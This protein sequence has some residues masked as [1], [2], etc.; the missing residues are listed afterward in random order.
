MKKGNNQSNSASSVSLDRKNSFTAADSLPVKLL[1]DEDVLLS[2]KKKGVIPPAHVQFYP[3]NKCNLNCPFCSCAEDD[4]FSEMNI[5][6]AKKAIDTCASLGTKAVTISG[7]GE[8]LMHPSINE[9][10][11]YF[12]FKGIKVGLVSNGLL[13]NKINTDLFKYVTWCR[14]SNADFRTFS[15]K[16]KETL[17]GVIKKCPQVDW[18]F[19]HVVS[20]DPNIEEICEIIDF[21]NENNFTHVRLVADLFEPHNVDLDFVKKE[22]KKYKVDD[23]LVIYQGRQ[24]PERGGDCYICYLKPVIGADMNVYSCCGAQ[25]FSEDPSKDLPNEL[26]LGSVFELDKIISESK[27]PLDGSI[28]HRCYYGFYNRILKAMVSDFCHEE[29]I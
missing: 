4:R 14:I 7:G 17:L 13:F 6:A 5:G 23:S 24:Y 1:Q 12:L 11:S 9:L 10:I 28:C 16:Y 15:N 19:S 26:K 18:A 21:A 29:F 8:P 20:K 25:Y 3:T 22:I 27:I 2:I